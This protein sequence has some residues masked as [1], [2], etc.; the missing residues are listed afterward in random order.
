MR[1]IKR[2]LP[3][4]GCS[5]GT[6]GGLMPCVLLI[7]QHLGVLAAHLDL[8]GWGAAHPTGC[9]DIADLLDAAGPCGKSQQHGTHPARSC[10]TECCRHGMLQAQMEALTALPSKSQL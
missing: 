6:E 1:T 4:F 5:S 3:G 7:S 9:S 10:G 2:D 8:T